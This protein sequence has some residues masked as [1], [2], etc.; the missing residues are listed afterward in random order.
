MTQTNHSSHSSASQMSRASSQ[1]AVILASDY[2]NSSDHE[3]QLRVRNVDGDLRSLV[4]QSIEP[5]DPVQAETARLRN[6]RNELAEYLRVQTTLTTR[7][8]IRNGILE[9]DRRR[10]QVEIASLNER[11]SQ[12][13]ASTAAAVREARRKQYAD[14]MMESKTKW[15]ITLLILFIASVAL[16]YG[17]WRWYNAE[18][19]N[20]IRLRRDAVYGKGR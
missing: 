11:N 19:F 2:G 20:Y 6:Q 3:R 4:D 8:Q 13:A 15:M 16:V 17:W 12:L 10:G 5:E 9:G 18:S 1:D 14:D 7:L